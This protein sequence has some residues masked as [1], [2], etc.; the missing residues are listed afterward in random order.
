MRIW[1]DFDEYQENTRI[2]KDEFPAVCR[3]DNQGLLALSAEDVESI[4]PGEERLRA[5]MHRGQA[6]W[7]LRL[8]RTHLI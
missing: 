5:G 8:E 7:R 2:V 6:D 3:G 4:V 1:K